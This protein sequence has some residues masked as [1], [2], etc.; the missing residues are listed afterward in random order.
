MRKNL[1]LG[2]IFES[3]LER[4]FYTHIT[5]LRWAWGSGPSIDVV[6][7]KIIHIKLKRQFLTV[8]FI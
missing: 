2:K 3:S 7:T 1:Y 4:F 5:Y 8:A 6:V